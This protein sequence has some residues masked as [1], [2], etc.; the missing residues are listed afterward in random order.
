MLISF[1]DLQDNGESLGWR[2]WAR[3][4]AGV[5]QAERLQDVVIYTA[6]TRSKGYPA[7]RW[8]GAVLQELEIHSLG[9]EVPVQ[10]LCGEEE[11]S[12]RGEMRKFFT[13]LVVGQPIVLVSG[14]YHIARLRGLVEKYHPEF[15]PFVEYYV[16]DCDRLTL[17][18]KC[19]EMMKCLLARFPED[20]QMY[21][22]RCLERVRE[23]RERLRTAVVG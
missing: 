9:T 13:V 14:A 2:S 10:V 22:R 11:W 7:M 21:V 3:I 12:S 23:L 8:D 5:L 16:V 18:G 20:G 6:A 19:V 4:I 15:A 17:T 1:C